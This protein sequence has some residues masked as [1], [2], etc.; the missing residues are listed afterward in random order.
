MS[1]GFKAIVCLVVR[2]S[3]KIRKL[4]VGGPTLL[5]LRRAGTS[6]MRRQLRSEE[7]TSELQSPCNLVCRLL[8]EKKTVACDHIR[9]A[10]HTNN[11][12]RQDYEP[13]ATTMQTSHRDL[14]QLS[15]ALVS[16]LFSR[17]AACAELR[18]T[19]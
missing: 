1:L 16:D 7:H 10:R 3:C 18:P 19:C 17:A 12:E 9:G 14:L 6:P 11:S 8:L 4:P 2:S 15:S 13:P 5:V